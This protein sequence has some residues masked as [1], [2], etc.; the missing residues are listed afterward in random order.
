MF[1]I[2]EGKVQLVHKNER[3]EK[4]G[5]EEV[6]ACDLNFVW[7]T[8]NGCLAMFAPDLRSALYKR[9][10]DA[11]QEL[12]PDP[13]HLTAL[14]FPAMAPVKWMAGE[15]IGA[16]LTFHTGVKT[17]FKIKGEKVC[18]FKLEPK[19]GGTVVVYFQVQ[20]RPNEQQSGK[21]SKFYADKHCVI[22]LDPPPAPA[23][24]AGD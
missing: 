16:D 15:L 24:L 23:D 2:T 6:L 9:L 4:H 12:D 7:E 22:T 19:E 17:T 10:D 20:C 21:L 5:D 8:G 11:Q 13:E 18:K 1:E 3:L 14:R